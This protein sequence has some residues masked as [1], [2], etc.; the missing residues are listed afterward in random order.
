MPSA[1]GANALPGITGLRLQK[2]ARFRVVAPGA[3]DV[4]ARQNIDDARWGRA[5]AE[6][7][8]PPGWES[9][10]YEEFLGERR[11]RMA[12]LIRA[13]CRQL[14]GEPE[15]APLS[16]PWFLPSAE[17]R[18]KRI[19]ETEHALRNVVAE[20]FA[21][22]YGANAA[23]RIRASLLGPAKAALGRAMR[24]RAGSDDIAALL[25]HLYLAQLPALLFAGDAWAEARGRFGDRADARRSLQEA[26]DA[27]APVRNDIAH[28]REEER[29]ALMRAS[30]AC[31][32]VLAMLRPPGAR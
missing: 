12:D 30:V 1:Q 13:V 8:L 21:A 4:Q 27:I 9:M 17:Q 26:V 2:T 32:D 23:A 20:V 16:P 14:D 15:A 11:R 24:T 19:G 22:V 25:D 6:H 18:W 3:P 7:A 31:D 5:C 10:D 29:T 28:V